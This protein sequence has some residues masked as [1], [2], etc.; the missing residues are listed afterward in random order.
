MTKKST[1]ENTSLP[2]GWEI[3]KLGEVS[4]TIMGQA[5]PGKECNREGLGYP[6]VKTGQFGEIYPKI[7]EWTTKPLKKVCEGDVLITVVG[8]TIGKLNL[9]VS[10][11]IGRSVAGIRVKEGV[12]DHLFLYNYLF[13]WVEKLRKISTGAAI[14][15]ISKKTIFDIPFPLPPLPQQK[16]IV[17]ILDKAFAAI[18][19]AK[20]NAEQNLQNAK[21]LF[22]SYLHNIFQNKGDDWEE[23][24]LGKVCE[25][26]AGQSPE[27]KFYN[28]NEEGLAFYQGKKEFTDKYIG[29]PTKWTT[30]ITKEAIKNDI[31]M[32]V[33][34]PVGPVNFSIQKCCIG[35]GLAAIRASE[36]IDKEYL[37]NFL[38]KFENE[39]EGNQGAVFNSINK[40][41]IASIPIPLPSLPQQ[42]QIVQKLDALSLETKKLE[43]IYSQKIA[44][45]EEMKKSV[46][47]KAFSGQL[48]TIN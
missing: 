9:G 5:P 1:I 15:V 11:A 7:N 32:S 23:V 42:K 21:E 6:F 33:R 20:V 26:I 34:A 4:E 38:V 8:A 25:V 12:V 14:T 48:N 17:A 16:Q 18:D 22:E 41:Q 40:S 46:L 28:T 39:I 35:R 27:S 45:L 30:K 44:D 31:L 2:A 13:L 29:Q 3:K 37:Y 47:Q 24:E 43:A 36:K 10:C 19:T